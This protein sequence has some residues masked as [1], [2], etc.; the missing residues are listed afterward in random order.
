MKKIP[1]QLWVL[2]SYAG[3]FFLRL[4]SVHFRPTFSRF[5]NDLDNLSTSSDHGSDTAILM[6]Q[7]LRYSSQSWTEFFI[8]GQGT[9]KQKHRDNFLTRLQHFFLDLEISDE[10]LRVCSVV[11]ER[12]YQTAQGERKRGPKDSDVFRNPRGR[13][14]LKRHSRCILQHVL[15]LAFNS[16]PAKQWFAKLRCSKIEVSPL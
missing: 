14:S 5:Q 8:L 13:Y 3:R 10:I 16:I 6:L 1:N 7:G 11:F 2:L 4:S 15:Y 9:S 12:V